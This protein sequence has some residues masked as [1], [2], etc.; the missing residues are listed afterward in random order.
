MTRLEFGNPEHIKIA[1]EGAR[2][3]RLLEQ[4]YHKAKWAKEV[5]G[6]SYD[7]EFCT[8]QGDDKYECPDC[9]CQRFHELEDFVFTSTWTNGKT[10]VTRYFCK[11]C[12]IEVR[13]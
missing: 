9:G 3:A 12:E 2:L 6:H 8:E 1:L 13:Q 10:K 7:Y 11:D 5:E 4:D